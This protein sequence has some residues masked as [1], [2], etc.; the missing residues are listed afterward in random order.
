MW[1]SRLVL[2]RLLPPFFEAPGEP[3]AM[4]RQKKKPA[5]PSQHHVRVDEAEGVF[6]ETISNAEASYTAEELAVLRV[7]HSAYPRTMTQVDLEQHLLV[8]YETGRSAVCLSGETLGDIRQFLRVQHLIHRARGE[9][10]GDQLTPWG[11]KVVAE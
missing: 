5:P 7:F 11:K 3:L 9:G 10:K 4:A 1:E 8:D 2:H 6:K